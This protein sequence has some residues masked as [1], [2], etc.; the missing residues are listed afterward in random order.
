MNE[1]VGTSGYS[2]AEWKGNFYP[3]KFSQKKMLEYYAQRFSTVEVNY[4]F[5]QLPTQKVV[6]NV[7]GTS[8]GLV[9]IRV[10]GVAVHHSFQTAAERRERNG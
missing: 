3:E 7:G 10:E 9:S 6:E 2:H 1:F 8:A 4:T 5:R